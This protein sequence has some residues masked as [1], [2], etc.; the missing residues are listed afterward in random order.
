MTYIPAGILESSKIPV[1]TK[2]NFYVKMYWYV[3]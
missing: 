3:K 2:Q 1:F